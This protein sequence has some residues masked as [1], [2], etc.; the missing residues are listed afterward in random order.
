MLSLFK[1][2]KSNKIATI[3]V[4]D[5]EPD[6][7]STIKTRLQGSN[8]NVI[9]ASNGHEGLDVA[10]KQK[11]DLILLDNHMPKMTGL[12]MLSIIR[13]N[14]DLKNTPV[15]MVTAVCEPQ[16]ITAAG[17]LGVAGYITKPFDFA[18]LSGKIL[19]ALGEK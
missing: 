11:P 12:E 10:T 15:I 13:E 6:I 7:L 5:D 18:D 16:Y 3:L 17:D 9:T 1:S 14:P 4:V 19:Q 2:K 8:Y